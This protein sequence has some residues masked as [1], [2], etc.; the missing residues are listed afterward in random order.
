MIFSVSRFESLTLLLLTTAV[1]GLGQQPPE[2][3][4]SPEVGSDGRVTFRLKA[5]NAQKA[6]AHLEGS[7]QPLA[8]TKDEK[9]IWSGT[10]QPLTPDYYGYSFTVDG[11]RQ[12]DPSNSS[13]IPNLLNPSNSL[14]VPGT[15][16]MPWEPSDIPHGAIHHH[17]YRSSIVGDNR[18]FYVYTPPNYDPGAS[19]LYPVLYLLHGFSDDASGWTA[20]GK[21]NYILDTL[22]SQ[23]KAKPMIVVMPLGYGAPEILQMNRGGFRDPALRQ[24]NV[25]SFRNALIDEV[26]PRVE[27]AYKVS[28]NRESRAIAGL[29]MGGAESLLTG[30]NRL[31]LFSYVGSFSAGGSGNDLQAAFPQI[32][33]AANSQLH[34]LWIACGTED[35]LITSNRQTVSY[36]K[37]K[38]VQLTQ[39]ET[40]GMHTWMV[41]RRN[42]VD[43]APLLFRS[44]S[45]TATSTH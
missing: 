45:P 25:D 20:V 14:H 38:G 18:D 11:V 16:I 6:E 17:F 37:G 35:S 22:I 4:R 32:S 42:L 27:R 29:S 1:A 13:I 34:L 12:L 26:M 19:T 8:L 21:A 33:A 36:L 3:I 7:K 41:W 31:D 9:G 23:S 43:F 28:A 44:D 2:S 30:L 24:R 40:P 15:S 10:T 39:I 5:P